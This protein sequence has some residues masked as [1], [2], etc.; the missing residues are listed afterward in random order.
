NPAAAPRRR[1]GRHQAL[2]GAPAA[3]D[4]NNVDRARH[5]ERDAGAEANS[6]RWRRA[7]G[8]RPL[9]GRA[10]R[11]RKRD[12]HPTASS[13]PAAGTAHPTR[14]TFEGVSMSALIHPKPITVDGLSVGYAEGGQDGPDAILMSPWP[15]S[16]YAFEPA[17]PP[18]A[19]AAHLVAIDPPGFGG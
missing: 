19:A 11:R 10:G 1:P 12:A 6:R 18:L 9:G 7:G 15:E 13:P 17:W 14:V 16:V 8:R 3:G 4:A 5:A 2:D